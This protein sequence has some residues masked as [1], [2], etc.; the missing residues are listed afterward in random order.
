MNLP[1]VT[2]LVSGRNRFQLS[3]LDFRVSAL[4]CHM[5]FLSVFML[6]KYQASEREAQTSGK[7]NGE[8]YLS[9]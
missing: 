6:F 9:A 7:K 8:L 1:K 5:H 2:Q 4:N 3:C